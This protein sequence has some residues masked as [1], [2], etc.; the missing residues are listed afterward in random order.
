MRLDGTVRPEPSFKHMPRPPHME[1]GGVS[2]V[3]LSTVCH[4]PPQHR[5]PSAN[6][7]PIGM[8]TEE[9]PAYGAVW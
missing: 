1:R 5:N 3:S 9:T 7:L 8:D 2:V 6:H 4:G